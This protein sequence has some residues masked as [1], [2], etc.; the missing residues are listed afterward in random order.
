M[1]S[2][3][4][5]RH[6]LVVEDEYA[7]AA[8]LVAALEVFGSAVVGPVPSVEKALE[9]IETEPLIDAAIVDVNLRGVMA[10]AVAERL[11]AR[12]IPFVFTSGY[13]HDGL[14]E[15]Y[16]KIRNC[17]KPYAFGEIEQAL[18]SAMREAAR[19]VKSA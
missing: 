9:A 5:D 4:H 12:N 6:I 16:P 11:L 8:S 18:A 14:R 19:H 13:G 1:T 2:P 7:V 10:H 3:L 17:Q 15:R